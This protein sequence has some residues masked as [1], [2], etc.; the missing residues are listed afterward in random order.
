MYEEIP[1]KSMNEMLAISDLEHDVLPT[2][3]S[4]SGAGHI[5]GVVILIWMLY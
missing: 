5:C 2:G 4:D 1:P 3:A